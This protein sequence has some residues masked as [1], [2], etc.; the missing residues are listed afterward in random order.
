MTEDGRGA[1]LIGGADFGGDF[2][3]PEQ[4]WHKTR[5][6]DDCVTAA[7]LL[8]ITGGAREDQP[9]EGYSRNQ[10]T[11]AG[12]LVQPLLYACR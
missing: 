5:T 2:C 1:R 10:D 8:G 4:G 12:S 11:P 9:A 7:A 6:V 3:N